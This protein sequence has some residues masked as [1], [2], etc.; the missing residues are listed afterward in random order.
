MNERPVLD[1]EAIERA[2]VAA[3]A[4]REVEELP[5]W[6]LAFDSVTV[7]R[8]RSA[9]PLRHDAPDAS[10]V[11]EIFERYRARG[12]SP[13]FRV[14]QLAA[15]APVERELA[16]LGLPPQQATQVMVAAARDVA[17]AATGEVQ[18]ATEPDEAWAAVFLGEGFDPA[19]G[20]SRVATLR[21]AKGS[22]FAGI[23]E[24]ERVVAGGVLALGH[25]WASI[26]GMRT[27][28]THRGRGLATRVLAALAREALQRGHD[29]MVLQVEVANNSATRV[30]R[31]CG[32]GL[33]WTYAYWR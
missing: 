24:G 13:N 23:R 8:A 7:N 16:R 22:L 3:V 19:D 4:P 33:A 20:A 18:V 10:V 2:T 25:G 15:M 5:G 6:L 11:A 9:V 32:F 14:A 31:R 17:G 28:L 12:V 21:R 1:V 26:H 27:A 29:R 30:Y